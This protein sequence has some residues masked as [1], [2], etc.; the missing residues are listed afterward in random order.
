MVSIRSSGS[1]ACQIVCNYSFSFGRFYYHYRYNPSFCV[2]LV[3]CFCFAFYGYPALRFCLACCNHRACHSCL[4]YGRH[5]ACQFCH[6]YGRHCACQ[7]CHAYG[8]H[9]ADGFD[10]VSPYYP[11]DLCHDGAYVDVSSSPSCSYLLRNKRF[12]IIVY[13]DG[14]KWLGRTSI[15]STFCK[16]F[17]HHG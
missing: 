9:C 10:P 17:I 8:R 16:T 12:Y 14:E 3:C 7:F 1:L 11:V 4:A 5:R 13:E 15:T 6:A 2:G